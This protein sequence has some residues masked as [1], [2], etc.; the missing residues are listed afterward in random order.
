MSATSRPTPINFRW[1]SS[2]TSA[3]IAISPA[4]VPDLA[5]ERFQELA[6]P[7]LLA[8]LRE[9]PV[10]Y[11]KVKVLK[12]RL[13]EAAFESFDQN[14]SH[15]ETEPGQQFRSFLKDEGRDG[16]SGESRRGP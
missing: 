12:R 7:Q 15:Q 6:P 4:T 16:R 3:T 14:H 1:P 13:L 11:P 2:S 10:N 5:P 8:E 9:G